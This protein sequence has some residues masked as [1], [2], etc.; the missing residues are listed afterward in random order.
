MDTVSYKIESF[1]SNIFLHMPVL[2][3]VINTSLGMTE[4]NHT[5]LCNDTA[6]HNLSDQCS[7]RLL[8][9]SV[10]FLD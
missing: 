3:H 1:D 5:P 4:C 8:V 9:Y 7:I 6:I 10:H 2:H